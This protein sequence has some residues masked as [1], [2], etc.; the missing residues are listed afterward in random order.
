M[1]LSAEARWFWRGAPPPAFEQWFME[2]RSFGREAARREARIDQYLRAPHQ[3]DL[4]IKQRGAGGVEIKGLIARQAAVLA[5]T[6]LS[7]P[8]EIWGKWSAK[9]L[10]LSGMSLLSISKQRWMRRFE[11]TPTQMRELSADEDGKRQSDTVCGC[12]IELTMLTGPDHS[13]WWT[14]GFESHGML[15]DIERALTQAVM[16][17]ASMSP[18]QVPTVEP[19]SYPAWLSSQDW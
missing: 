4:G 14:F 10:D 16:L 9:T 3:Q 8:P 1:M 18:P 6:S 19:A 5:L 2:A 15:E 17:V 7:A 13:V 11:C 12:E